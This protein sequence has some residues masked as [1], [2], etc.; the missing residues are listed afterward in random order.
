[1]TKLRKEPEPRE[2]KTW[3][4]VLWQHIRS[5]KP[6][7]EAAFLA[8]RWERQRPKSLETR[9]NCRPSVAAKSRDEA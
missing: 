6:R 7:E 3:G 1:M 5:G 4:E 2:A 9:L 8:D